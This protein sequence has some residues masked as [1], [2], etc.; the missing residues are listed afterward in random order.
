MHFI[1]IKTNVCIYF[2]FDEEKEGFFSQTVS[3]AVVHFILER[4]RFSDDD[5]TSNN[6]GIDKLLAEGVYE[7]AYPLHDV[8]NRKVDLIV[9]NCVL[10]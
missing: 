10:I 5:E 7:A 4:M 3:I 8:R 6:V 1:L 9:Y 2:S